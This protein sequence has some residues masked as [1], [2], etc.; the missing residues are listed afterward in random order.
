[1]ILRTIIKAFKPFRLISLVM[2]YLLGAGL[3]QYV[4]V[5]TSWLVLI[6]GGLFLLFFALSLE[7]LRL[8][9]SL[10]EPKRWPEGMGLRE[11][12]LVR[13]IIGAMAA[14]FLTVATTILIA[15]LQAGV[16]W[17]GLV[18]LLLVLLAV[19]GFYYFSQFVSILRPVVLLGEVLLFVVIPPAFAYFLQ[20]DDLHHYLTMVVISLV[21]AYLAYRILKHIQ[22]FAHDQK[23]EIETFVTRMGWE[24]AMVYHNALI[25][26]TYF[27][28]ALIALLGIHWFLIWPVFLTLPIGLLEIWLIERTRRGMKPLW[29]V[30]QIAA[31][32]VL[33]IPVYLLGFAF[34]IR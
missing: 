13:I 24:N 21:P 14:T 5:L 31:A 23:Y 22:N 19:S 1:M 20:S 6:Q 8:L 17:Q 4:R 12:K 28:F 15:W 18:L 11:A 34:W 2:T 27:L 16:I 33:W 25:L 29:R 10:A 32:S 26:L 30:M 9:Q 7:L 3:V